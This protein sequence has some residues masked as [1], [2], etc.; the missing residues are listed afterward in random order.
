MWGCHG[1][2][3]VPHFVGTEYETD[4]C[5]RRHV[6]RNPDVVQLFALRRSC[7]GLIGIDGPR[8]LTAAAIEGLAAIE[9]GVDWRMKA[10]AEER[11]REAAVKGAW[12]VH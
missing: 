8:R 10:E 12:N 3:L 6:R 5:P 4:V 11:A 1:D 7:D 9:E 2:A